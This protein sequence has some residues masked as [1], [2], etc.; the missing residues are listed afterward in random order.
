ML[1]NNYAPWM[2]PK[3]PAD[4]AAVGV[5]LVHAC[6]ADRSFHETAL[7]LHTPGCSGPEAAA[8]MRVQSNQLHHQVHRVMRRHEL[9]RPKHLRKPR[10]NPAPQMVGS[11]LP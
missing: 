4:A 7:V 3:E 1:D 9:R 11:P 2:T 10:A 8:I 6:L 5:W